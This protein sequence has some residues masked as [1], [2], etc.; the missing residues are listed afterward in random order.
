VW[1]GASPLYGIPHIPRYVVR[2]PDPEL[3]LKPL[4][5][6]PSLAELKICD[7]SESHLQE[8][9]TSLQ[10]TKRT[11][12]CPNV[13]ASPE[14][15]L[16]DLASPASDIW[17]LGNTLYQIMTGGW[18]SQPA[19]PGRP[20]CSRDEVLS[21]MVRMF[22][23]LPEKWWDRWE[24][25][26]EYFDVEGRWV[27]EKDPLPCP[28]VELCARMSRRVLSGSEREAFGKI[29]YGMLAYEPGS[30]LTARDLVEELTKLGWL[31]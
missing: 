12:N 21:S 30:R 2:S 10:F 5:D 11:M 4:F 31:R 1:K 18:E 26:S 19:I 9:S 22:G 16:D 3:F 29:L 15:I 25:R 28:P 7:F 6:N 20:G 23:K 24:K 8:P 17:A 27:A 14:V 13:Y